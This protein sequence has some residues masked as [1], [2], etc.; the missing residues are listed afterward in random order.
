MVSAPLRAPQQPVI[1]GALV[2]VHIERLEDVAQRRNRHAPWQRARLT[3]HHGVGHGQDLVDRHAGER[4]RLHNQ[5]A[6]SRI[7]LGLQTRL[8][9]KV[10]A[11][12][13]HQAKG[14]HH[15]PLHEFFHLQLQRRERSVTLV[16]QPEF[17]KIGL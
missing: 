10:G 1:H 7:R 11:A 3:T 17:P 8:A 5:L 9:G 16:D 12:A 6:L 15:R 13:Q 2:V 4:T 14:F